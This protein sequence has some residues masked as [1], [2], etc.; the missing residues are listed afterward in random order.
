MHRAPSSR[1]AVSIPVMARSLREFLKGG[2]GDDGM[3]AQTA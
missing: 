1:V 2:T 3:L